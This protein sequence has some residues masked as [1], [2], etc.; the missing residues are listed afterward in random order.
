MSCATYRAHE[1]EGQQDS[2]NCPH[3]MEVQKI[4]V[5]VEG[6]KQTNDSNSNHYCTNDLWQLQITCVIHHMIKF[7]FQDNCCNE[8]LCSISGCKF[9]RKSELM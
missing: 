6:A 5:V 7:Q 9:L 4:L 1:L 2:Q 8:R 3:N